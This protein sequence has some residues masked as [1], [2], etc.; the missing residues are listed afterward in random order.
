VHG[1]AERAPHGAACAVRDDQILSADLRLAARVTDGCSDAGCILLE[2]NQFGRERKRAGGEPFGVPPQHGL[3]VILSAEAVLCSTGQVAIRMRPLL[4]PPLDFAAGQ[5]LGPD[6]K[7]RALD[8]ETRRADGV[9]DTALAEDLHRAHVDVARLGM[10]GGAR[11]PFDE[12]RGHAEAREQDGGAQTHRPAADD[13]HRNSNHRCHREER[14][15][16]AISWRTI[17]V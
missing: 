5:R 4:H 15:N 11:M 9:F 16:V 17:G 10:E 14:S 7:L 13:Q 3:E 1:N 8:R 2:A 12:T 6:E